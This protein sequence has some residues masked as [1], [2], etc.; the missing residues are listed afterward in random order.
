MDGEAMEAMLKIEG[1]VF[2]ITNEEPSDP[3][4]FTIPL[5]GTSII[6]LGLGFLRM[7][8]RNFV[9]QVPMYFST[10]SIR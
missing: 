1:D 5:R 2:E 7:R 6:G 9:M 8:K 10:C 4:T 3:S